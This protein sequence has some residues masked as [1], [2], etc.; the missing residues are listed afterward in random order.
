MPPPKPAVPKQSNQRLSQPKKNVPAPVQ[1]KPQP[2]RVESPYGKKLQQ[3]RTPQV[4]AMMVDDIQN[5]L[6]ANIK[7]D[8][9]HR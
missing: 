7:A 1:K 2:P 4:E 6:D 9:I 3:A 8:N 5:I